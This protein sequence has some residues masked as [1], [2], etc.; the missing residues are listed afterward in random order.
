MMMMWAVVEKGPDTQDAKLLPDML[1]DPIDHPPLPLVR[2]IH[3]TLP[4]HYCAEKNKKKRRGE[5]DRPAYE[6]RDE[7]QEHGR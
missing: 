4:T 1:P 6:R 2:A 7:I 3:V 5:R